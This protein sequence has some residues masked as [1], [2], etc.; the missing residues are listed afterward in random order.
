MTVLTEPKRDR[1][2]RYM[3]P[4]PDT[5]KERPWTRAT[6]IAGTL[7]DRYGLEKWAQR[8]TV[9]GLGLRQD[10]YA[11]AASCTAEDKQQLEQ[12]VNQ[13]QEAAKAQSGANLGTALHKLTERIDSGEQLDVPATWRPDIDAYLAA[14]ADNAI[15]VQAIEQIVVIPWLG[16]AGTLDR[17]VTVKGQGPYI[18]DLKTGQDVVKY[19]M[20]E[21]ALQLA[22]YA[23]ATHVWNGNG[24]DPMP[25]VDKTKALVVHLPVGQGVCTLHWVDIQAGLEAVRLA[26][27]VRDWRKRR[28]LSTPHDQVKAGVSATDDW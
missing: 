20:G 17:L 1:Y 3:L 24:Y 4:D 16:V 5:G 11:L 21:I 2:G 9:L 19:G 12:I 13:A 18:A 15:R 23:N 8:N 6:T 10:L 22:L 26:V 7:A 14:F 27:A 25:T 28:D